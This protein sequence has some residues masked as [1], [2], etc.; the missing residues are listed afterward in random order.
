MQCTSAYCNW[1]HINRSSSSLNHRIRLSSA[2]HGI[3]I[4]RIV[5]VF[6]FSRMDL[7][8]IFDPFP[9]F[10]TTM[11]VIALGICNCKE[12]NLE[13]QHIISNWFNYNYKFAM[14]IRNSYQTLKFLYPFHLQMQVPNAVTPNKPHSMPPPFQCPSNTSDFIQRNQKASSHYCFFLWL[15]KYADGT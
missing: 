11:G 13:F 12:N 5:H 8:L 3:G 7:F 10:D 1:S 15:G 4:V 9:S 2:C 6:I 14:D